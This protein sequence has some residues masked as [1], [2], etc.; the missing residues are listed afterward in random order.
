MT[1]M[2]V[3]VVGISSNDAEKYPED[4]PAAMASEKASRGYSFAYLFDEDQSVAQAY[5]AACTPDF[6]GYNAA[7]ELQYR[8]R[9]DASR[10]E[11]APADARRD[12]FEAMKQVAE[13]GEGPESGQSE[14]NYNLAR[15]IAHLEDQQRRDGVR[16]V[17]RYDA[18][19]VGAHLPAYA[20]YV[21]KQ[22]ERLGRRHPLIRRPR[23]LRPTPP[24]TGDPAWPI[25][26]ARSV[27]RRR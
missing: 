13:T 26:P 27:W 1:V 9:L 23:P 11:A 20:R 15:T 8:G 5:A 4:S 12:L 7:G 24:L 22:V 18:E 14:K 17:F 10:K 6:F 21:E 3:G 2:G 25:C 16:R 19:V